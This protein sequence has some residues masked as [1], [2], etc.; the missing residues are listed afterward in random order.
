MDGWNVVWELLNSINRTARTAVTEASAI[1]KP[2]VSG[3]E[4]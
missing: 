1:C 2:G 4:L 3:I